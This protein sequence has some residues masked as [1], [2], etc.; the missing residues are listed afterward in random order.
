MSRSWITGALALLYAGRA[1]AAESDLPPEQ[2]SEPESPAR[3]LS[4]FEKPSP[5]EVDYVQYG[6]GFASEFPVSFG[7]ICSEDSDVPCIIGVG[8]GPVI[9]S[10][11]RPSGPWY[12]GGSYG[13][14]KLD[15]NNLYR[16]GI[17]Q[18]LRAEMRYL[19][20]S[21]SRLTPYATWGL[22]GV[23][24]GNE[25]SVETGGALTFAGAGFEFEVT[26]FAVVGLNVLYEPALFVGFTDSAGQKRETGVS[27]FLHLEVIIE[28]R[29][30]LSR[31]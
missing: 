10:G 25:F 27:Q 9:R 11:Y 1:V 15:S 30:E 23:V 18:S 24:Y 2:P 20:D 17:L 14:A 22:G 5:L 31:E 19:I 29:T 12:V 13:F 8:G 4:D 21:G 6:V 3:P 16:L 7:G 26:R 28:L